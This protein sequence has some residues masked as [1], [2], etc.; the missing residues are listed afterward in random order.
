[1]KINHEFEERRKE[2][3][4]TKVHDQ[5]QKTF[6]VKPYYIEF[7]GLYIATLVS[8]YFFNVFSIITAFTFVYLFFYSIS[9][10]HIFSG[11]ITVVPLFLLE[12]FKRGL[13]KN[14]FKNVKQFG[15]V[16]YALLSVCLLLSAMSVISS[17]FGGECLVE[18]LSVEYQ[19]TDVDTIQQVLSL[20]EQIAELRTEKKALEGQ[21]NSQGKTY[22]KVLPSINR[23][24][25]QIAALD[26]EILEIRKDNRN[27]ERIE[28]KKHTNNISLKAEYFGIV[29][30]ISEVLYWICIWYIITYLYNSLTDFEEAEKTKTTNDK[31]TDTTSVSNDNVGVA[32]TNTTNV[33]KKETTSVVVDPR[34]SEIDKELKSIQKTRNTYNR[35]LKMSPPKVKKETYDKKMEELRNRETEL[36]QEKAQIEKDSDFKMKIV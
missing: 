27:D 30:A 35:R 28:K 12:Y 16:K 34:V 21:K 24:S 29:A 36:K 6:D 32:P 5:A 31:T 17:Y 26:E 33:V 9:S 4:K 19:S 3:E 14:F 13:L 18:E 22:Y 2:F 7:R 25:E 1:M 8:S 15:K 11:L 23:I 20:Q 10:S